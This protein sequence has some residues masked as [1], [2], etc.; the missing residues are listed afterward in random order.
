MNGRRRDPEPCWKD[1][2][3]NKTFG[4]ALYRGFVERGPAGKTLFERV[5]NRLHLRAERSL[6][7]DGIAGANGR[8]RLNLKCRR[9]LGIAAPLARGK[10]VPQITHPRTT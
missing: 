2:S 7:H 9:A 6:D 4:S 3:A 8:D 1:Q 10:G 5:H